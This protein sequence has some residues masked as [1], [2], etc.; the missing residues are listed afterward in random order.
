[1]EMGSATHLVRKAAFLKKAGLASARPISGVEFSNVWTR[2]WPK[3]QQRAPLGANRET[4]IGLAISGGVD[5]MALAFLCSSMQKGLSLEKARIRFRA[6]VVDHGVRSGSDVEALAVSRS[7]EERDVPSHVLKMEWP[8]FL[9]TSGLPN[10][11]SSA[12]KFRFRTLGKACRE[13]GINSLFLAHHED[14]QVETIMMRLM[15]GHRMGLTGIKE[16]SEI[17]E[18]Y[19]IHGVHES[20]GLGGPAMEGFVEEKPNPL[21]EASSDKYQTDHQPLRDTK[22]QTIPNW[23]S[24]LIPETGGVRV[25]RPLLSFSKERLI[26]TCKENNV[27]W[28]E[29]HTNK[30]R[31]LTKRNAIRHMRAHHSLPAAL[32]KP[33][34]LNL[35]QRMKEQEERRQDVLAQWLPKCHITSLDLQTGTAKVRFANLDEFREDALWLGEEAGQTAAELLRKVLMLVTP[36]EHISISSLHGAVARIFP[37]LSKKEPQMSSF[38]VCGVYF[39]NIPR[40][41]PKGARVSQYTL[42]VEP[43]HDSKPTWYLSRQP[44]SSNEIA[45]SIL[46]FPPSH[47]PSMDN[48][49]PAFQLFDGRYWI[50]IHARTGISKDK[51]PPST[52]LQIKPLSQDLWP[53]FK[54][55]LGKRRDRVVALVK[56]KAPGSV[57]W[58]LPALVLREDGRERVLGLPTLGIYLVH[59]EI[60]RMVECCVRYKKIQTDELMTVGEDKWAG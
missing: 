57:R 27:K 15:E 50:R 35:A 4:T 58:T 41:A 17:P 37:E 11:E 54:E 46:T 1:M 28:F 29:D 44:F 32:S 52:I 48:Q 43:G 3:L 53:K 51:I 20:G 7:L 40:D 38:T 36:H 6:F 59:N 16:H 18:C 10:F 5:S 45:K 33:A 55:E 30:D 8:K 56:E 21:Q 39:Q 26:A 60:S 34:L 49:Q 42:P 12:R 13:W 31:T 2:I 9:Q 19:G 47:T 24:R 23:K 14:D 22:E 25:Y